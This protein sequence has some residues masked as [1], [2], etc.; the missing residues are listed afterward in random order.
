[1]D[2][3]EDTMSVMMCTGCHLSCVTASAFRYRQYRYDDRK[4]KLEAGKELFA[5]LAEVNVSAYNNRY[6]EKDRLHGME[7]CESCFEANNNPFGPNKKSPLEVL[8]DA[9]FYKYQACESTGWDS[10]SIRNVIDDIEYAAVLD[11]PGYANLPWGQ[12]ECTEYRK[13]V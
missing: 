3:S 9:H 13:H 1:M 7:F 6:G 2:E 5:R 12:H 8:K 4:P 11:L 10:S